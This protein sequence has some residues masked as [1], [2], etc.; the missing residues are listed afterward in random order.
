LAIIYCSNKLQKRGGYAASHVSPVVDAGFAKY[1]LFQ[2]A[3]SVSRLFF[4]YYSILIVLL[5]KKK[6]NTIFF[7]YLNM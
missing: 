2:K 7:L 5:L 1:S 3:L 6:S 4:S